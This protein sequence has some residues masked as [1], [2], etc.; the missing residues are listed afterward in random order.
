MHPVTPPE[1]HTPLTQKG[2][3]PCL[4]P[5]PI[6]LLV[7][8]QDRT[9]NLLSLIHSVARLR[10]YERQG[11]V[12]HQAFASSTRTSALLQ[13]QGEGRG[14]VQ[15]AIDGYVAVYLEFGAFEG[16]YDFEFAAA[17]DFVPGERQRAS[18]EV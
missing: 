7:P 10:P 4:L 3:S 16:A 11:A 17:F 18:R 12:Y 14:H 2:G 9:G 5:V 1:Q 15:V 8:H 13:R 6:S